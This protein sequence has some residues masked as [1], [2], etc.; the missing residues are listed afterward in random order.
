VALGGIL[1]GYE[2]C[3]VA[4]H[5]N[6]DMDM[7]SRIKLQQDCTHSNSRVESGCFKEECSLKSN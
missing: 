6:C 5:A 7:K 2:C 1:L 4:L 3:L